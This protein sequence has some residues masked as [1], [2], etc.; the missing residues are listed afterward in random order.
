[1]NCAQSAQ[2]K[3]G[4]EGPNYRWGAL[5]FILM[6]ETGLDWGYSPLTGYGLPHP[7]MLGSPAFKLYSKIHNKQI[8][9]KQ[10]LLIQCC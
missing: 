8:R 7:P 3:I 1:M 6:G 9:D 4:Q 5:K 2:K 10:T